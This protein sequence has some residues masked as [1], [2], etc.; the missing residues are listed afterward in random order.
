MFREPLA[1]TENDQDFSGYL[2]PLNAWLSGS[3]PL[4][5]ID[6]TN[7]VLDENEIERAATSLGIRPGLLVIGRLHTKQSRQAAK[8]LAQHLQW[9]TIVDLLSGL[10]G[11]R[12]GVP[13]LPYH[14]LDTRSIESIC[15]K[16]TPVLY[17]GEQII[18]KRVQLFFE[19]VRPETFVRVVEYPYLSDPGRVATR[20]IVGEIDI[21]CERLVSLIAPSQERHSFAAR[22]NAIDQLLDQQLSGDRLTEPAVVRLIGTFMGKET[23]LFVGNSLPIRECDSF[24]SFEGVLQNVGC[25]RG[26]SGIDG[27]IASAAGFANGYRRPLTLLL[28]DLTFL[29][30]LSSLALLK[31]SPPITMVL[32]NNDGGGIFSFLPVAE[33]TEHFERFFGTPHGLSFEPAAKMFELDYHHPQTMS[34]FEK[35]YQKAAG[36]KEPSIIEIQTDRSENH[37]LHRELLAKIAEL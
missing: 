28:G 13:V 18:S 36:E 8:K 20:Q 9:P 11:D 16:S 24:L 25:N 21:V 15:N 23:N 35:V 27:T 33:R 31:D 29:H 5:T 17:I 22:A 19:R 32:F 26:G 1:P 12:D 14:D 3:M 2:G 30:D 37:E 4:K 6:P 7:L 10:R 34:E